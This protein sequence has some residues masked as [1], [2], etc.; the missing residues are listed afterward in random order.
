MNLFAQGRFKVPRFLRIVLFSLQ[1]IEA[2]EIREYGV[3]QDF[4]GCLAGISVENDEKAGK[5]GPGRQEKW[6]CKGLWRR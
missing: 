4:K 6:L 3:S 1:R 2:P 5:S